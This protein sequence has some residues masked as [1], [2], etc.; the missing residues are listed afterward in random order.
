MKIRTRMVVLALLL[1]MGTVCAGEPLKVFILSGQ[2]NMQGQARLYTIDRLAQSP[3]TVDM[4]KELTGGEGKYKTTEVDIE[5]YRGKK[6]TVVPDTYI[7]FKGS[8]RDGKNCDAK[9]SLTVG[10]GSTGDRIGTEFTFGLYMHK[11]LNEPI[12]IIKTAWGGRDLVRQF[13][14]PSAGPYYSD[15]EA[16]ARAKFLTE[17]NMKR[18]RDE[19]VTAEDVKAETGQEYRDMMEHVQKVLANI[20]E[21]HPAYSKEDGYEI[22]GFVWFQGWNDLVN[23]GAYPENREQPE[24]RFARY[25]D[26]L[27]TFIKDVRKDLKTPAMPFVIGVIGVDGEIAPDHKQQYLRTAMAAP[28]SLDEFKGTV[29]AVYTHKQWDTKAQALLDKVSAA[30]DVRVDEEYPQFKN[31]PRAREGARKKL[32]KEVYAE[33]LSEDEKAFL[34]MA[35]SNGGYHYLGSA[36]TYGKIGQA[37][38]DAMAQMLRGDGKQD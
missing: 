27:A 8:N 28:A 14:S 34:K 29:K 16:E 10:F 17:K 13:R 11:Y 1:S 12:L 4:Y 19:V 5:Q 6:Y 22:A 9:G 36:Y 7:S 32:R 3:E 37:F 26:L 25:S 24:S 20:E 21:Y 33:A 30:L 31:K 2:S 38:A 35:T 23:K 18:G 15:E